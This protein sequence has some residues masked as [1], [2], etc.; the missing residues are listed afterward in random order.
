MKKLKV[1]LKESL[2]I[3]MN[4]TDTY[5]IKRIRKNVAKLTI[6]RH[7]CTQIMA[8]IRSNIIRH[9]ECNIIDSEGN[10]VRESIDFERYHGTTHID[11]KLN[12]FISYNTRSLIIMP[13]GKY[14]QIKM[15]RTYCGDFNR[16]KNYVRI[17][18]EAPY[19]LHDS[20][21][22]LQKTPKKLELH[23]VKLGKEKWRKVL[24]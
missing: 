22:S 5:Q 17:C 19:E 2:P 1:P 15:V 11:E 9:T 21:I 8:D 16:G 3:P 18:D 6:I 4:L 7:N 13:Q 10:T 23:A 24:L 12:P 20:F 14:A